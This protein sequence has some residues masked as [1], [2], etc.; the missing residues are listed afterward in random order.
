MVYRHAEISAYYRLRCLEG[1]Q[2]VPVCVKQIGPTLVYRLHIGL[3]LAYCN[4]VSADGYR[5]TEFGSCFRF[6]CLDC[7]QEVPVGRR[8]SHGP[9][10]A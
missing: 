10:M 8:F 9:D 1:R 2:V 3:V 6:Q 7:F 4:G 5:H